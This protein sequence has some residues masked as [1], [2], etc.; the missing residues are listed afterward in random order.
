MAANPQTKTVDD[1]GYES[2]EIGSYHPRPPSPRQ[3]KLGCE[4]E[5]CMLLGCVASQPV[6]G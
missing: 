6:I 4:G 2:A 1:L 5:L 3:L